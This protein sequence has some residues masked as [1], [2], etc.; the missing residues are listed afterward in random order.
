VKK[1]S[2]AK[3]KICEGLS[4][5]FFHI[6]GKDLKS[7][8]EI[9]HMRELI[10]ISGEVEED[11]RKELKLSEQEIEEISEIVDLL[12]DFFKRDFVPGN[13]ESL[14]CETYTQKLKTT[15]LPWLRN[16]YGDLNL[17]YLIDFEELY[18]KPLYPGREGYYARRPNGPFLITENDIRQCVYESFNFLP[19][20]AQ[21][22]RSLFFAFMKLLE[23]IKWRAKKDALTFLDNGGADEIC[24]HYN[25][26]HTDLLSLGASLKASVGKERRD[27][28]DLAEDEELI[29][30]QKIKDG[31]HKWATDDKRL[32]WHR[33]VHEEYTKCKADPTYVCSNEFI[34]KGSRMGPAEINLQTPF[35]AGL[36]W[37]ILV[38]F[39]G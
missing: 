4:D 14:T 5:N 16:R 39:L 30:I 8:A 9:A 31:L 18:Q 1:Q 6:L 3:P 36:Y 34:S 12:Q 13:K 2:L 21:S 33:E 23:A 27:K 28:D 15:G 10:N 29:K 7:E 38:I 32:Q 24:N 17:K 25:R 37:L 22:K 20:P 11:L 19:S 26:I 35:R